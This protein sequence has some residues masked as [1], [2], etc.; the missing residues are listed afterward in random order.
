MNLITTTRRLIVALVLAVVALGATMPAVA[1]AATSG[2]TVAGT[3][4]LVITPVAW[5]IITGLALPF[6]IAIITKA[7][8][9]AT[10]KAVVGIVVAA[11][12][13]VVERAQLADG[14]AVITTG[15]L[16]DVGLIYVPQLLSYLGLWS[17]VGLNEK[18]VPKFGLG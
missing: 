11:V 10:L 5:T 3:G 16:L 1:S 7:S 6:V 4:R 15:L 17:H 9:S 8:A 2:V 12:A 18:V 13:A 14:S